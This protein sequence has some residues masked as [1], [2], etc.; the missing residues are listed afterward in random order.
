MKTCV[1]DVGGGLRDIYAVGVLDRCLEEGLGFDLGVGVSAGSAN[2]CS[3]AAGQHGRSYVFYTDYSFRKDYMSQANYR[4]KGC[5]L[6][7]HYIYGV[8]SDSDGEYPLD[9][10]ALQSNPMEFCFVATDAQTGQARYFD[11]SDIAQDD[12]RVLMASCAMPLMCNPQE[13]DGR[14]YFDGDITDPIPLAKALAAGC[15]KVVLILSQPRHEQRSPEADQRVVASMQRKYPEYPRLIQA[16][17]QRAELYNRELAQAAEY[18]KQGRLLVV[19][20]DDIC[21]LG[22]LTRDRQ[23]LIRLYEKGRADGASIVDFLA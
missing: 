14:I 4:T 13:I 7:V 3:F 20:P 11:K 15:D 6:D 18:E 12:Y 16:L 9:Y 8:L 10:P 21:G 22:S 2:L 5:F 1:I 17:S 23:A 19:A